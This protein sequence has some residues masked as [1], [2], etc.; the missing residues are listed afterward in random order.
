MRDT[1]PRVLSGAVGLFAALLAIAGPFLFI[2]NEIQE[3]KSAH[4]YNGQPSVLG[5]LGGSAAVL[6]LA[7]FFA[8]VSYFLIRF[9]FRGRKQSGSRSRMR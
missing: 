7:L 1:L 3:A 9:S 2:C 4:Q 5:I 8:F 6:F